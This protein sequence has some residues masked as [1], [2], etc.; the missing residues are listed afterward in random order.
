MAS[1]HNPDLPVESI[2]RSKTYGLYAILKDGRTVPLGICALGAGPDAWL[3][4][5]LFP[6]ATCGE[7]AT[8][9]DLHADVPGDCLDCSAEF[10]CQRCGGHPDDCDGE[11][12]ERGY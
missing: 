9:A 1:K 4:D 10:W 7:W 2:K 11:T 12:C 8:A 3:R 5:I 6:C